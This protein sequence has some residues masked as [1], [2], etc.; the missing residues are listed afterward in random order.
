L[1]TLAEHWDGKYPSL[2]QLW[3]RHWEHIITVFDYPGA[4]QSFCVNAFVG[5]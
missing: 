2:S 4:C 5:L 3:L 1:E